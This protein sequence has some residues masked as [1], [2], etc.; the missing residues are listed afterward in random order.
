MYNQ[1]NQKKVLGLILIIIGIG[2]L[3][4]G[5]FCLMTPGQHE[6]APEAPPVVTA[7]SRSPHTFPEVESGETIESEAAASPSPEVASIGNVEASVSDD[8]RA[9]ASENG[10]PQDN[11]AKGVEFE[12]YVVSRFGTKSWTIKDWRGDKGVNGRYAEANTYPDLEM[13]LKVK[14][15]EYVIAVECK[16]RS[17]F[18]SEGKIKW[19]YPD[20]IKR[21]NSFAAARNIPV[22]V[23]IG[24][25]GTPSKPGKLYIVPLKELSSHYARQSD[26]SKFEVKTQ[27]QFFYD[28]SSG[29]FRRN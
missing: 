15:A 24:V 23:F 29:D 21:Y 25:G 3:G 27:R 14:D 16:W 4:A 10:A 19:S 18:D 5:I 8:G 1:G 9:E 2:S 12:E 22:F 7:S 26:L 28:A 11:H 6:T 13:K 17:S 20:Q